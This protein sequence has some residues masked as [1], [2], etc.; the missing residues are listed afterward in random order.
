MKS[1]P[2]LLLYF[3][4]CAVFMLSVIIGNSDLMLISKPVI[5]PAI[6][7]YYLQERRLHVNWVYACIIGLFFVG[8]MILLI[9]SNDYFPIMITLFLFGYLLYFKG[10]FDDFIK[11]R[12]HFVNKTHLLVLLICVF[13]LVFLQISIMDIVLESKTDYLWL[14]MIYGVVLVLIGLISSW[15]YI[16]HP[17]GYTTLMILTS[18]SFI[19]SD[20]FYILKKESLG[21]DIFEYLNNLTQALSYYFL[22]KYFLLKK[23]K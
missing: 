1:K 20:V 18:L 8:D 9:D 14:L 11:I 21:I 13:L 7:F 16:M 3:I 10:I 12:S 23:S 2:A 4:A 6:F 22:T 19:I 5:V 17:S 15:N